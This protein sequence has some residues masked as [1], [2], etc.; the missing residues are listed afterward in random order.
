MSETQAE[1]KPDPKLYRSR[2]VAMRGR[3]LLGLS[4]VKPQASAGSPG[5]ETRTCRS[6]QK[7]K[8]PAS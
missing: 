6:S 5:E 4:R 8:A 2:L 3:A 7:R 1:Q